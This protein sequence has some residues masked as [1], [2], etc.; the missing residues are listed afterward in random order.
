[1]FENELNGVKESEFK[2]KDIV[3]LWKNSYTLIRSLDAI[4]GNC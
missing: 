3:K 2:E 4:K 1:M